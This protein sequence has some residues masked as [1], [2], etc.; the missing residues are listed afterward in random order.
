ML[1]HST[2]RT[3]GLLL[4]LAAPAPATLLEITFN[5]SFYPDHMNLS[6]MVF[7]YEGSDGTNVYSYASQIAID[8]G[9]NFNCPFQATGE[10]DVP[11]GWT[12][13]LYSKYTV[14]GLYDGGV[15]L[16]ILT[17]P[18]WDWTGLSFDANF[19]ASPGEAQ[20]MLDATGPFPLPPWGFTGHQDAISLLEQNLSYVPSVAV[21]DT[22]I[23]S[24]SS[25]WMFTT[26]VQNGS[27]SLT[28][29]TPASVPEPGGAVLLPAGLGAL[30]WLLRRRRP[31]A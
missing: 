13:S 4:A 15:G 30:G 26:G 2:W 31:R 8:S 18:F 5:G 3:L 28:A 16:F 22:P 17:D 20:L 6:D 23:P 25:I 12:P 10:R 21:G 14:L 19:G 11:D 27:F 7:V 1:R 24:A 29:V 9:C